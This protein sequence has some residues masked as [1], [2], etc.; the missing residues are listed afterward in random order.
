MLVVHR[1]PHNHAPVVH[2]TPFC[3]LPPKEASSRKGVTETGV[4]GVLPDSEQ[5]T[6]VVLSSSRGWS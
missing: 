1:L 6:D 2:R 4:S 3:R 5:F